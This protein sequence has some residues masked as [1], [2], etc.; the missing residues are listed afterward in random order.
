[1]QLQAFKNRCINSNCN[2]DALSLLNVS[3]SEKTCAL[4]STDLIE[5][6][7]K[8]VVHKNEVLTL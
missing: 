3:S 4:P 1:M 2:R 8:S 7:K 6:L 5:P